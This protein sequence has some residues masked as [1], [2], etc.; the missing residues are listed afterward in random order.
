MACGV[1][2]VGTSQILISRAEKNV[3]AC[4]LFA[5]SS[6]L[7]S[8][9]PRKILKVAIWMCFL[10]FFKIGNHHHHHHLNHFHH[11]DDKAYALYVCDTVIYDLQIIRCI[12]NPKTEDTDANISFSHVVTVCSSPFNNNISWTR[13]T[14][15]LW[16]MRQE[17]LMASHIVLLLLLLPRKCS[18]LLLPF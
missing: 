2:G 13:L 5:W 8:R 3:G 11:H 1:E 17:I 7:R 14:F 9:R 16:A 18:T 4:G 15:T 10:V 6:F 12:N